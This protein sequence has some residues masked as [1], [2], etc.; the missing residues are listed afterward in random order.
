[1]EQARQ[2]LERWRSTRAH[3]SS[4]PKPLWATRTTARH[5]RHGARFAPRLHLAQGTAGIG[6]P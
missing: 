5:F 3:R 4:I 6:S 1:M 2:Q